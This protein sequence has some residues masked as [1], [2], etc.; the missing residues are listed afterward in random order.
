MDRSDDGSLGDNCC[1]EDEEDTDLLDELDEE[2]EGV[3]VFTLFFF[4][5]FME[6]KS[7]FIS[8]SRSSHL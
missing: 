2:G 4:L 6:S 3:G 8:F 1:Y 7:S 5:I